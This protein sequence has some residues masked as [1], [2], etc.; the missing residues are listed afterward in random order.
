[1]SVFVTDFAASFKPTYLPLDDPADFSFF[2]DAS[3][4][5]T[6]YV[7]P[8]R[9]YSAGS[10]IARQ[11][12]SLRSGASTS[13]AS[14]SS[15][16]GN[17]SITSSGD[18]YSEILGLG[19]RDGKVTEAM[20]VFSLGCVISELWRD[21]APLFTLSQLFKYREGR[22][23]LETPLAEI[24]DAPL[25]SMIRTMLSIDPTHRPT[26]TQC[27]EEQ[28]GLFPQIFGSFLHPYLV[29]LQRY[30]PKA[31]TLREQH[32]ELN[33]SGASQM[34]GTES[35]RHLSGSEDPARET[36]RQADL[37]LEHLYEEWSVVVRHLD[38]DCGDGDFDAMIEEDDLE[39]GEPLV[40]GSVHAA[41]QAI[42]V[43]L[44]IPRLSSSI[45]SHHRRHVTTDGA[46]LIVLSVILS[47]LRNAL[48]ASSKEHALDLLLHLS[49][50]W[51]TDEAKLDRVLP[52][53]VALIDDL[54]AGVRAAAV[55]STV[56]LL[57]LVKIITPA[58]E[59]VC[60]EYIFP[61]LRRIASDTS[62][63][64]RRAYASCFPTLV[65]CAQ[66]FLQ[67]TQALRASGAFV[68]DQ[69]TLEDF[70]QQSEEASYDAQLQ[71]I[72]D[73]AQ[74]QVTALLTDSDAAVKRSLL[75][76]IAP[77]CTL[78]GN[79]TTNDVLLSHMITYLNDRD[80][81]LRDAF[82]EAIPHLAIVAGS[83]S[84]E[85][86]IIPLMVQALSD[87]EDFVVVRVLAGL[88]QVVTAG[89]SLLLSKFQIFDLV[90]AT[91]GFLCHSNL[92]IR[93]AAARFLVDAT[94]HLDATDVWAIVYPSIRPLLKYELED[95]SALSII[96]SAKAPLSRNILQAAL[97]WA[98]TASKTAFWK[99]DDAAA[100]G[101][102][103]G[104]GNAIALEGLRL[105]VKSPDSDAQQIIGRPLP[106][107]DEDDGFMDKLR[108]L[109][110][111][112]EDE[113]KLLGL[114]EYIWKVSKHVARQRPYSTDDPSLPPT[115]QHSEVQKLKEVTPQTI[116]FSFNKAGAPS[117][118]D[119]G[120]ADHQPIG[121]ARSPTIRSGFSG[122]VARRR[123]SEARV[124]SAGSIDF[125]AR[126][127]SRRPSVTSAAGRPDGPGGS[128]RPSRSA[129]SAGPENTAISLAS[130]RSASGQARLG[131]VKAAPAS[132][133]ES[134]ANATGTMSDLAAKLRSIS[135]TS[136]LP[137]EAPTPTGSITPTVRGGPGAG[138]GGGE[139]NEGPLFRSTYEGTDPY[140]LA[141]LEMVFL[142]NFR[143]RSGELGPRVGSGPAS[144]KRGGKAS[145]S[146]VAPTGTAREAPTSNSS[147][148]SRR[149]EGK[150]VAYFN[151]HTGPITAIAVSPDHAFFAS[152]SEDGTVKIWDT[153]RL[154][155]NVTSRSRTTYSA[156]SGQITA[157]IAL[158][159]THC[160]V[161]TAADGSLHVWRVD[162][163][164]ASLP[165][166]GKPRLISNFQLSTPGEYVVSLLQSSSDSPSAKL[167]LG[168]S[169]SRITIL[170]LRT[171]QV[172]QA[173]K[174][175]SH[176]GPITCM[177]RDKQGIWLLAGTLGGSMV[178]WDLRF[179]LL[180]KSW[181]VGSRGRPYG[182][183]LVKVT[184]CRL[185][186]SKG[187]GRWVMISYEEQ[188][189]AKT[190]TQTLIETWDIDRG[191]VVE[192]YEIATGA[193]A[194]KSVRSAP[195]EAVTAQ[196]EGL[197]SATAAIE[198]LVRG[199]EAR[200]AE[201]A[202]EHD[203]YVAETAAS[204]ETDSHVK[205]FVASTEGYTSGS[206][207]GGSSQVSGGW[208]DA[209][210]LAADA[211][212]VGTGGVV[213]SEGH[214]PAGYVV[215][216]GED[217]K[218]R[219]WDLG[220]P[221]R[222]VCV[223]LAETGKGEFK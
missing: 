152:G 120:N 113:V 151:E 138:L 42:P 124:F 29:D 55:H 46:G 184:E 169:H 97:T 212:R 130:Q 172:L 61:N 74:E 15:S 206:L 100:L 17:T 147:G 141:H 32:K 174:N 222:S 146:G 140:I 60:V 10:D 33:S 210:K 103:A 4:R 153:A 27:L 3:G 110:F 215:S 162:L 84:V 31:T 127:F 185:H 73:F 28:S 98:A 70:D 155:K 117:T 19:K 57:L 56:Q 139:D 111:G 198:Q 221:E 1:L 207:G 156:H 128:R 223:S 7:A 132:V 35:D 149:P 183:A 49:A 105:M 182:S 48:R 21:G 66:R 217:C 104:V 216:A 50:R 189:L 40:Q 160:F 159:S 200:E 213:A 204:I 63:T 121:S 166:Y 150:L 115:R 22:Y 131:I 191:V 45:L 179:G 65:A 143:D 54:S 76:G 123:I 180:V 30:T 67:Q 94:A 178:L 173:L 58:N 122:Q 13:G 199:R 99:G 16:A 218:I 95:L 175:P 68:A 52:Y 39:S 208:L 118:G 196:T 101:S 158:E 23:D 47:N 193:S 220:K 86:Y 165:R 134:S 25:R 194:S 72:R 9:F 171:M 77:M 106:R 69:E 85:E 107:S 125:A 53:L 96:E 38:A 192:S 148:G 129:S 62:A 164:S 5:R 187:R 163:S 167:I 2:F 126:D 88:G 14:A 43:Q 116:F 92:W 195:R 37:R 81:Q 109:G 26:F 214:G 209:G 78:L 90:G 170:D 211:D 41:E 181:R 93:Q 6:C 82:F 108:A 83:R 36:Q 157:L 91:A 188:S 12:A 51:L 119:Q 24:Q 133:A 75:S 202:D 205:C 71:D 64:V 102:K 20:D 203:P 136:T 145:S 8:E 161:S 176:F 186:P 79:V 59:S 154:E 197:S 144:R 219:F 142:K 34:S 168:T 18:P 112:S 89:S 44:N 137:S 201:T 190:S 177:C 11:K 87:P 114:R 135:M 80:W